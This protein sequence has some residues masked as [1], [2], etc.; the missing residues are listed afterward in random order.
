MLGDGHQRLIFAAGFPFIETCLVADDSAAGAVTPRHHFRPLRLCLLGLRLWCELFKAGA[1]LRRVMTFGHGHAAEAS[2]YRSVLCLRTGQQ[3]HA[4]LAH[5]GG[6]LPDQIAEACLLGGAFLSVQ[7]HVQLAHQTTVIGQ[8]FLVVVGGG[9]LGLR[10][11]GLR[12]G[13]AGLPCFHGD[14]PLALQHFGGLP[15]GLERRALI[16]A[17][18]LYRFS[19]RHTCLE[20]LCKMFVER[21]QVWLAFVVYRGADEFV[22]WT[23]VCRARMAEGAVSGR[24]GAFICFGHGSFLQASVSRSETVISRRRRSMFS[25]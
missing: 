19:E 18:L 24:A 12:Q 7:Q 3:R 23:D 25:S 16:P 13:G 21:R 10:L 11:G 22:E 5:D 20:N 1:T 6:H 15:P 2:D 9:L 17:C 8:D 4:T 14:I